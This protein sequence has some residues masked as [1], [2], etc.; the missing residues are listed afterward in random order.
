MTSGP[1]I[2]NFLAIRH[3]LVQ[4]RI[5]EEQVNLKISYSAFRIVCDIDLEFIVVPLG[6]DFDL[7]ELHG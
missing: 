6:G 5:W 1:A 3:R 2:V 4:E 7:V